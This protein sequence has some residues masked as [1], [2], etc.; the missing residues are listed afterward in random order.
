MKVKDMNVEDAVRT[1]EGKQRRLPVLN[2]ALQVVGMVSLADV[3]H[4]LPAR[5]HRHRGGEVRLSAPSLTCLGQAAA[6]S[7]SGFHWP[8]EA[9]PFMRAR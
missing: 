4:A 1:M 6:C 3:S 7:S 5:H 8:S 2:E 9:S